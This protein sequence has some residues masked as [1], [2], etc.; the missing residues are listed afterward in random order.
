M[1]GI[2]VTSYELRVT[3][4]EL[5]VTGVREQALCAT[6]MGPTS[7]SISLARAA[8]TSRGK[9]ED[10]DER[11]PHE[12]A[13]EEQRLGAAR[14][15]RASLGLLDRARS[16]RLFTGRHGKRAPRGRGRHVGLQLGHVRV[17][18]TRLTWGRCRA[19]GA[20]AYDVS[21]TGKYG[22]QRGD[23]RV[24]SNG[25]CAGHARRSFADI[26][27]APGRHIGTARNE[28]HDLPTRRGRRS[29][30]LGRAARWSEA[31]A[32]APT[33]TRS[34]NAPLGARRRRPRGAGSVGRDP[35]PSSQ[36][37]GQIMPVGRLPPRGRVP[38]A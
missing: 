11:Q 8:A 21:F 24:I 29:R 14:R 5:R 26:V 20:T 27:L 16:G 30:A 7:S 9:R 25:Q 2:V 37:G 10:G 23:V 18:V 38:G 12:H 4:Y 36:T 33:C 6:T 1:R 32:D 15:G 22:G 3:S 31:S 34:T 28:A 17:C 13:H 35:P 19:S